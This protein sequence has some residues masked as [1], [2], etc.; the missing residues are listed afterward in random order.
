MSG[1]DQRH[2]DGS[3]GGDTLPPLRLL[4]GRRGSGGL[5]G[6][7]TANGNS[8][9]HAQVPVLEAAAYAGGATPKYGG[10]SSIGSYPGS[11][12]GAFPGTAGSSLPAGNHASLAQQFE[13]HEAQFDAQQQEQQQ[14]QRFVVDPE[15]GRPAGKARAGAA[16]GSGSPATPATLR[17]NSRLALLSMLLLVFQGT[18]LSIM[19]RYSRARAGQPYLASVSGE[20]CRR[21]HRCV[22]AHADGLRPCILVGSGLLARPCA[23]GCAAALGDAACYARSRSPHGQSETLLLPCSCV[24]LRDAFPFHPFHLCLPTV[25][26]PPPP[27]QSSSPRPSS[28]PSACSCST[29]WWPPRWPPRCPGPQAAAA[30]WPES[31]AARRATSPPRR[32]PCCCRR[33]C[34]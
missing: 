26:D 17:R 6:A 32:C 14:Q 12:M 7:P 33:P 10:S 34:L 25:P 30:R 15:A 23:A 20:R 9:A 4:P 31:C 11:G 21:C 28:W 29:E 8:V 1:G 22:G 16:A 24:M 5:F 2:L 18:A 19:L 13:Q 3:G 27:L